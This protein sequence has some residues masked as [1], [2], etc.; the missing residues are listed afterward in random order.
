MIEIPAQVRSAAE[1]LNNVNRAANRTWVIAA[2]LT[3]VIYGSGQSADLEVLGIKLPKENFYPIA[4]FILAVV[5]IA[6]CSVETQAYRMSKMFSDV[7]KEATE[8]EKLKNRTEHPED[9]EKDVYVAGKTT[10]N[11]ASY[12]MLTPNFNRIHPLFRR[13]TPDGKLKI[14]QLIKIFWDILFISVPWIGYASA[15]ANFTPEYYSTILYKITVPII[16]ISSYS[17]FIV[18]V[19][20]FDFQQHVSNNKNTK[21]K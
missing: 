10:L 16:I 6:L 4:A 18:L 12:L 11:E 1:T 20:I 15:H 21:I 8:Q 17:S 2:T 9:D 19:E 5:N 13:I 3:I 7:V 14:Y